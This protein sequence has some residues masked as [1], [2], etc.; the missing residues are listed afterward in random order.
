M[1]KTIAAIAIL[2][3]TQA[4]ALAP[5]GPT[6]PKQKVCLKSYKLDDK[7]VQV[8]SCDSSYNNQSENLPLKENGCA[9]NQVALTVDENTIQACL[10]A[11]AVQL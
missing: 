5:P 7:S 11:G 6:I 10:P 4:H 1:K 9:K 3:S 8:G 2:A